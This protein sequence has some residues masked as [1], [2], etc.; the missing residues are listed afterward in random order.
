[1]PKVSRVGRVSLLAEELE[2]AFGVVTLPKKR[3][4]DRVVVG[5]HTGVS[6]ADGNFGDR[7]IADGAEDSHGSARRRYCFGGRCSTVDDR[8]SNFNYTSQ[9]RHSILQKK[10]C[11]WQW[12]HEASLA[13]QQVFGGKF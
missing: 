10:L 13:S 6:R 9:S 7:G 11:Y 12:Q 4:V 3:W 2:T 8:Q 5:L 1:M